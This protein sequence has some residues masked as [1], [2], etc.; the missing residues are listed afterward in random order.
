MQTFVVR[1]WIP[2]PGEDVAERSMHGVVEHSTSRRS[3]PFR[4]ETELVSFIHDCLHDEHH[5]GAVGGDGTAP[6]R[7]E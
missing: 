2:A 7:S 3:R 6:R 5:R 1:V 4:D